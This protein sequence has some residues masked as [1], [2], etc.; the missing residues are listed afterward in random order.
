MMSGHLFFFTPPP[1]CGSQ[2]RKGILIGVSR[3]LLM[4]LIGCREASR[5]M[6]MGLLYGT[7]ESSVRYRRG[8]R[9]IRKVLPQDTEGAFVAFGKNSFGLYNKCCRVCV[10]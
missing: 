9:S 3:G 2:E 8:F 10:I 4:A 1:P 5:S 7:G 6:W